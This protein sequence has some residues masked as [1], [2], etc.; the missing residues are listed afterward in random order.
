MFAQASF[1][2]DGLLRWRAQLDFDGKVYAGVL[3][4]ASPAMAKTLTETTSQIDVPEA[5]LEAMETNPDAGVDAACELM[6]GIRSSDAF[7]GVHLVPVLSDRQV[8]ARL[9]A[10]GWRH[11]L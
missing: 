3:V 8:V 10:D 11:R 1:D 4:V 6:N 9:E 5:L 7:D 2:L